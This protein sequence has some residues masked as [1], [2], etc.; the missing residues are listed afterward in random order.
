MMQSNPDLMNQV[1]QQ[2][3]N[4]PVPNQPVPRANPFPAIPTRINP[5]MVDQPVAQANPTQP[6]MEMP[7]FDGNSLIENKGQIKMILKMFKENPKMMIDM[8]SQMAPNS[9]IGGLQNMSERKLR[10]LANFLYYLIITLLETYAFF[11]RYKG[12][13][14]ILIIAC[15]VYRYIL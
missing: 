4:N 5:Q 8:I 2:M 3:G 6:N 7:K 9:P 13:M 12:Q 10:L 15:F 11:K 14:L 1:T